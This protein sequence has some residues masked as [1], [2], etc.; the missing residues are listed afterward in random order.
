[1][2]REAVVEEE[3]AS[4]AE[5]SAATCATTGC[6]EGATEATRVASTTSRTARG[7]VEGAETA[8]TTEETT[9]AATTDDVTTAATM[10]IV[11]VSPA[12]LDDCFFFFLFLISK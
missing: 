9:V 4:P 12:F 10:M 7:R 11:Y 6:G 5:A 3:V 1:M 8:G 2:E